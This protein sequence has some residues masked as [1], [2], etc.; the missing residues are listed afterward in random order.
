M[1]QTAKDSTKTEDLNSLVNI[2]LDKYPQEA[3]LH[4][5]YGNFLLNQKQSDEA[6]EQFKQVVELDPSRYETWIQ[7]AGFYFDSQDWKNAKLYTD[8]AIESEPAIPEGYLYNGIASFQMEDYQTALT[9]FMNGAIYTGDNNKDLKGQFY[10]NIGDTYYRLENSE[11]AFEYYDKAL[12]LDDHNI[13]VLNN[14]SYYLSLE[15]KELD[16]AANMSAKCVELEP[17]NSTYLDTY[18][19]VLYKKG[20]YT[21]AL[22]YIEKAIENLTEPNGEVYE[23]YGDILY[24]NGDKEKARDWWL[25]A[26]EAG[27]ES[28]DL[29]E[30]IDSVILVKE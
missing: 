30:K 6:L 7:I 20:S 10:A 8:K 29:Q 18:A 17:G 5:Y 21:L 15:N 25:K 9:A 2:M 12:E 16:K 24:A 27:Y 11:S 4:Y 23:H 14:Y 22:F 13:M 3:D 26:Q 1:L 19:W 28:D